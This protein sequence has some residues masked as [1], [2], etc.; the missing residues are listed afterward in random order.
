MA[1][2]FAP[3]LAVQA[4]AENPS[5]TL[6][7]VQGDSRIAR[8]YMRAGPHLGASLGVTLDHKYTIAAVAGRSSLGCGELACNAS[9]TTV[10]G[11]FRAQVFGGA[12]SPFA[13]TGIVWRTANVAPLDVPETVAG[14][15][16]PRRGDEQTLSGFDYVFGGGL[17]MPLRVVD[18]EVALTISIG[19]YRNWDGRAAPLDPNAAPL[20]SAI[21]SQDRSIHAFLGLTCGIRWPPSVL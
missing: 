16:V 18:L 13:L 21:P 17:A 5:G 6:L 20:S 7:R 4:G 14:L 9:T 3:S 10:G 19:Q 15:Y 12:V 11:V 1:I 2:D 8:G